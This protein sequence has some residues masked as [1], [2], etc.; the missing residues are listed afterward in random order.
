MMA[1]DLQELD[2]FGSGVS[3]ARQLGGRLILSRLPNS[4]WL[5]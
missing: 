2:S 5:L 4:C 1:A 3:S